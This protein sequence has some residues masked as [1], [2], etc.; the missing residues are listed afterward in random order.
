MDG[1]LRARSLSP[2]EGAP[3]PF[4]WDSAG[5]H[6]ALG[7]PTSSCNTVERTYVSSTEHNVATLLAEKM[8][9]NYNSHN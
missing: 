4:V 7:H 3:V 6:G 9:R 8:I 2:W 5:R 1:E